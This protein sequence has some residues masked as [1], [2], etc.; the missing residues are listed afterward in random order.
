[1]EDFAVPLPDL[2]LAVAEDSLQWKSGMAVH[3]PLTLPIGW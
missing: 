3:G 2:H 1:M